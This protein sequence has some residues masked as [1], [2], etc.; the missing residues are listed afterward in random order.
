MIKKVKQL[1]KPVT[2][3]KKT[4]GMEES[5]QKSR[6]RKAE[7]EEKSPQHKRRQQSWIRTDRKN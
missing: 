2:D 6:K 3:E 1:S 5:S 4:T 7:G